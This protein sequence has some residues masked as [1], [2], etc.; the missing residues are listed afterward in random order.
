MHFAAN[1]NRV[2]S[3]MLDKNTPAN[4]LFIK[5]K[6]VNIASTLRLAL[7]MGAQ[8]FCH[9]AKGALATP[10]GVARGEGANVDTHPG[11]QALRAHQH[12]FYSHLKTPF[13]Q[14]FRL[15]YALKCVFLGGEM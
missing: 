14:K 5:K 10:S 13:K 15:K 2:F 6:A 11:A 8:K 9:R 1:K 12:T 3:K 4:A 7:L